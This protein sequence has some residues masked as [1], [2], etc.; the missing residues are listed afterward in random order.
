M[1][2]TSKIQT[3]ATTGDSRKWHLPLALILIA[4]LTIVVY[5]PVLHNGFIDYDDPDY[6]TANMVVRQGLTL[7]GFIWSFNGFHAANWHPL[8]WLS[9]MLDVSLFG[10]NPVGHH[11]VSLLIHA[12]NSM[13]LCTFF[14]RLTG[15]IGRSVVVALL[16]AI[17]PLHVESVVWV[18]ERKDVLST[19]FWLLTMWAYTEYIQKTG[20]KRYGIVATLFALGLMAK[21]MLV[22][23]PLI[24]L[25][26]DYWPL[27]LLT[28]AHGTD[29]T[30]RGGV[31]P[32]VI[33]K[34]PLFLLA[35]AASL[36]TLLAQ[37][38]G[39]ALAHVTVNSSPLLSI[40]NAFISYVTYIGKM[41]WPL[42]LAFFY[43]LNPAAVTVTRVAGSA[44]LLAVITAF[45]VAYRRQRPYLVFGWF[46]Y[47]VTLLPVIGIIRIGD[48]A[49]ADRYTYVPL[50]GIFVI[51]V[52][53]GAELAATWQY[54][55][56][57]AAGV[58]TVALILCALLTSAQ[59]RYWQNSFELYRH[60]LAVV[61]G[62]W[63][64]HN[65][66]GKLLF[67]QRRTDESIVHF[68]ESVRLNPGG[69]VGLRNL[70]NACM[71]TGRYTES[72]E[73]LRQAVTV[74]LNDAEA[75]FLLGIVY[76]QTGDT[77]PA[78]QEYQQL[79]HLDQ[80]RASSLLEL[81]KARGGV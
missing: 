74:N 34:I 3:D 5:W 78:Y 51:V 6:V 56:Q 21:Q 79:L 59:V 35:A 19:L 20:L 16:F 15:F 71:A 2:N 9:H 26:M 55:L 57:T 41:L 37:G 58:V 44:I 14:Y 31:T 4:A 49:M 17:H 36:V 80:T 38:S 72:I 81:I 54:G 73:A 53:G 30:V 64:A 66:M 25:L 60:A 18:A 29:G 69:A 13:L 52:W 67:Q 62:N 39:G 22:T 42:D 8:T 45:A 1:A 7:K 75:H 10:L 27:C 32:F 23:L 40:G 65:N 11:V 24:L 48:Q 33:K 46:W 28:P 70:G 68:Q 43:P 63:L 77:G 61:D 76:L 47:L 50:I 12:L